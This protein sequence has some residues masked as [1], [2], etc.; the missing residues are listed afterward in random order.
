MKNLGRKNNGVMVKTSFLWVPTSVVNPAHHF[1][2]RD[3]F[4]SVSQSNSVLSIAWEDV[5][6]F[7][8]GMA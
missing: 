3:Q 7:T 4:D 1:Q 5:I 2:N 8:D 6:V